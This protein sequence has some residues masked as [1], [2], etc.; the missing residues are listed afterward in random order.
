MK[1]WNYVFISI[2]M[3]LILTF[4]GFNTGFTEIFNLIGFEFNSAT[5]EIGNVSTSAAGIYSTLFGNGGDISGILLALIAGGGA[6]IV[7]LFTKTDTENLILL[8]LITGTLVLFVQTFVHIMNYAVG[9]FPT[10][11]SA[12]I[13]VVLIPFTVG[14]VIALAE[15]FRGTD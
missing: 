3:M 5:G 2:T 11:A 9:T 8:P 14:F 7:G 12:V 13:L 15:M 4:L 6:I 10:W 1:V